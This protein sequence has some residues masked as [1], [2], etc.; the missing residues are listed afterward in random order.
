MDSVYH[1]SSFA[2]NIRRVSLPVGGQ[3]RIQS[4]VNPRISPSFIARTKVI[5]H[6]CVHALLD[7][8]KVGILPDIDREQKVKT[9]NRRDSQMVTHS[10]TSRL[11][12]CLCMAERTGCPVFT[13][14]WSYVFNVEKMIY[15]LLAVI[16]LEPLREPCCC[17]VWPFLPYIRSFQGQVYHK[18]Q[19]T[20]YSNTERAL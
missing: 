6:S 20:A 16:G 7:H 13:D 12:Q 8:C 18:W 9:H 5:D 11:V 3:A 15:I 17:L 14:L 4:T 2:Y 10:S 1:E 19:H